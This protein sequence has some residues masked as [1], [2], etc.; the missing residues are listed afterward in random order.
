M[1]FAELQ[2]KTQDVFPALVLGTYSSHTTR[3]KIRTALFWVLAV[4]LVAM[5]V[6][7]V[8]GS[9]MTQPLIVWLA[10]HTFNIRG[11][12]FIVFT[13]YLV[14]YL[15]DAM[16]YS[17]YFKEDA[18]M[19]FEVA[20]IV[21]QTKSGDVTGAFLRSELGKFVML[22]LGIPQQEVRYL[23]QNRTDF[24]TTQEYEVIA[25][26]EDPYITLAEY[27]R[28]LIHFDTDLARFLKQRGIEA[29]TFKGAVEW[30]ARTEQEIRHRE[31]W[32]KRDNLS[33]VPSI[34]RQWAYGQTYYLDK[35]GHDITS[36]PAYQSIGG[37]A[38]LYEEQ[39]NNIER[40]LVKDTG[41]NIMLVAEEAASAMNLVAAFAKEIANG[42]VRPQ[43]EGRR[44]YVLDSA[45]II[46]SMQDKV[47]VEAQLA[48]IFSQA[49]NAGNVILIIPDIPQFA[50]S[51]AA[52]DVDML[53][54]LTKALAASTLQV[55][56]I[57]HTEGFHQSVE[58]NR[59]LMRQFEK[60]VMPQLDSAATLQLV[61]N[62][63]HVIEAQQ[64]VLFSY[65]A[66]E[67][68]VESAERYFSEGSL[69]DKAVDLLHEVAPL[70]S[71]KGKIV[72]E[73]SDVMS[74]VEA[75]TGIPQG[76]L[77]EDEQ[78]KLE[79][80]EHILHER[81]IGQDV[82]V[83][84]VATALRR[85]RAGLTDP[86]RPMGSFMFLGPTGVGK[87]E[88][89]KA[90]AETFFGSEDKIIRI[91][92]SEYSG[93]DGLDKLIGS[94][95]TKQPGLLASKLREEQY[96]VL[97]LDEFE[98]ASQSVHDLFL[99]ML[100]EGYFTDGRGRKVNARNVIIIATSNAGSDIIYEA[101]KAGQDVSTKTDEIV[102][103]II[104]RGTYRPELLNRFDGTI[105]FH[106]LDQD[107]LR[108]VAKL[109]LTKVNRRLETKG[110][111]VAITDDLLA[112]LVRT[113]TNPQFGARAMKRAIQDDVER[114]IADGLISKKISGGDT[115]TLVE[116]D[117]RLALQ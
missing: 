103:T 59:D 38:R 62:E 42:T 93:D 90:L 81:I 100:D 14:V 105:V 35:F 114:V 28:S 117:G 63:T 23:L 79:N 22:R 74:L 71:E 3:Q 101:T 76:D 44:V 4:L 36:E 91:D 97:L 11:L 20:K 109:M 8:V 25:N 2:H 21:H 96:G 13:G 84:A 106:P 31:A 60:V 72:I 19:S 92:M 50:E 115:V 10:E 113:G 112:Y 82:A 41:A 110:V 78:H 51:A 45:H 116:Q 18:A 30:V 55:V 32:W 17:F 77:S 7:P 94:F 16:Y 43:L 80:L 33:R 75:R 89:T 69:S 53:D 108:E 64:K 9:I 48:K 37:K 52:V 111:H 102:N 5:L 65:Q 40:I 83:Q 95:E 99:Q 29:D 27:A 56:G 24:V 34:G 68:V 104:K 49:A 87:T 58:T 1:T 39:V 88:T 67:A 73:R 85:S 15:L 70:V 107:A 86:K 57:A 54:L 66:L 46:D 47:N 98:K 26:D 6:L 61:Q 12:F